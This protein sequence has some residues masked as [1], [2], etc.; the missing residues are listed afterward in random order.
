MAA[1]TLALLAWSLS[2]RHPRW[3]LWLGLGSGVLIGLTKSLFVVVPF[4]LVVAA[5]VGEYP[6]GADR[7]RNQGGSAAQPVVLTMLAAACVSVAGWEVMQGLRATVPSKHILHTLMGFSHVA[8]LQ[9]STVGGGITAIL[10]LFE[11]YFAPA[12]L[13]AVW[14]VAVFGVLFGIWF[15]PLARPDSLWIRGLAAGILIG[16]LA[17]AIG[18]PLYLFLRG[19]RTSRAGARYALALLP[20]IGY[21]IV[22]G[23]RRFGIIVVGLVLPL[24]CA[25]LQLVLAEVLASSHS[26]PGVEGCRSRRTVR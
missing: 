1:G 8:T 12:P 21:A 5:L 25:V 3:S 2:K 10:T 9:P 22:C 15:L 11:P 14:S 19:T 17:L 23:C 24:S 6:R 18:V 20:L 7:S 26:S 13:N 16:I 4:A